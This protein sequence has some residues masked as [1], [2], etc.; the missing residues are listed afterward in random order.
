MVYVDSICVLRWS[1]IALLPAP[2]QS[3]RSLPLASRTIGQNPSARHGIC[4]GNMGL[5]SLHPTSWKQGVQRWWS[6]GLWG[7]SRPRRSQL[8]SLGMVWASAPSR[9]LLPF[10]VHHTTLPQ[11]C[12]SCCWLTPT[13]EGGPPSFC[14]HSHRERR[15]RSGKGYEHDEVPGCRRSLVISMSGHGKVCWALVAVGPRIGKPAPFEIITKFHFS[16]LLW[17]RNGP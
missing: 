7:A 9:A 16:S 1:A 17:W 5:C 14:S 13:T 8:E 2:S 12:V 3:R 15:E 6:R 4:V 11:V 10:L